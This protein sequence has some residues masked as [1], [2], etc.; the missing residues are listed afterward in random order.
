MFDP[1]Y[2]LFVAMVLSLVLMQVNQRRA[3]PVIG[4]VNRWTRWIIFSFSLSYLVSYYQ[5]IDKPYW[6][7]VASS[8]LFWFLLETIYNWLMISALSQSPVNIFPSYS[9]NPNGDEWPVQKHL[10]RV[11]EALR[12]KG[13]KHIQALRAEI[14]GGLYLRTS[15]YEEPNGTIR[16]QLLFMPQP[17]GAISLGCIVSSLTASGLRII[18][19]NLHVP[20][21]GFYPENWQVDRR[22]LTRSI[23]RL[24]KSHEDRVKLT[25]DKVVKFEQSPASDLDFTQRQ[26]DRLNTDLGFLVPH[27]EREELGKISQEGRYRLWKEIWML[28]Y[29]GRSAR[30]Y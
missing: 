9:L 7:L 17:S 23:F 13:Y 18:T 6:A 5:L 12:F 28:E 1:T 27:R 22:P 20:F 26:L 2:P 19:D 24:I 16:V 25:G 29:L 3:S 15:F 11:R 21:G 14:G 8:F 4:I 30:Y 10:L